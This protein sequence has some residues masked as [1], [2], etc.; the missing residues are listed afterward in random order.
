MAVVARK[1]RSPWV[2]QWCAPPFDEACPIEGRA[3]WGRR[4]RQAGEGQSAAVVERTAW[5]ATVRAVVGEERTQ[6]V[7][8]A[9]ARASFAPTG[10]TVLA[11]RQWQDTE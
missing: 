7:L 5:A 4:P 9:G 11:G 1:I 2:A 3:R 10:R 6:R 8:L